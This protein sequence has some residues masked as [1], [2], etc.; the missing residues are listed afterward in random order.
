MSSSGNDS[1]GGHTTE[2]DVDE[3]EL[4]EPTRGMRATNTKWTYMVY[5]GFVVWTN[6]G[7]RNGNKILRNAGLRMRTSKVGYLLSRA[8]RDMIS[9]DAQEVS[10]MSHGEFTDYVEGVCANSSRQSVILNCRQISRIADVLIDMAVLRFRRQCHPLSD[11]SN[12]E[13]AAR[14]F[15]FDCPDKALIWV[16]RNYGPNGNDARELDRMLETNSD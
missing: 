3:E 14:H 4:R 11:Q 1:D 2:T 8:A 15:G 5:L 16:A 13:E 9:N 10:N 6:Y 12:L 7:R